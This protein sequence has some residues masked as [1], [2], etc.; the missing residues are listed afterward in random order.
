MTGPGD[1]HDTGDDTRHA[2]AECGSRRNEFVSPCEIPAE[3]GHITGGSSDE[4]SEED[5]T[6][7]DI[8]GYRWLA[9]ER[10]YSRRVGTA[11]CLGIVKAVQRATIKSNQN[12]NLNTVCLGGSLSLC[13]DTNVCQM[14][15]C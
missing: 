14:L 12:T 9:S 1:A 11:H 8:E 15:R 5:G 10:G 2:K 6:Y 4:Q 7:W 13:V 3:K